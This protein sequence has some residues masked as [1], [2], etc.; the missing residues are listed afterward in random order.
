MS[1]ARN[2]KNNQ[3]QKSTTVPP[4]LDQLKVY[5]NQDILI[6]GNCRELFSELQD[7]LEH[8]KTYCKLRFTC[9]CD[10][11]KSKSQLDDQT[12]A[13]LLCVQCKDGFQNAW[14]LMVHAQA[15]HMLNI[16]ELGVPNNGRCASPSSPRDNNSP[17]KDN[18]KHT[19]MDTEEE[20]GD[21]DHDFM[22][23]G[24]D[25]LT[26]TP[27]SAT[28]RND[29]ELEE[30]M[31]SA[32]RVMEGGGRGG[33]NGSIMHALSIVSTATPAA[34]PGASPPPLAAATAPM[35]VAQVA[36]TSTTAVAAELV[37]PKTY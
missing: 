20:N 14:D 30:L 32:A 5:S 10:T 27:D 22:E 28:S 24:R 21:V 19:S 37:A 11:N 13:S 29:K 16:Y 1:T 7:L 23:N 25:G 17:D 34:Q 8:K 6:C 15:A 2:G 4:P 33:A 36:S 9:K 18:Q 12:T 35:V 26:G 31:A 3:S